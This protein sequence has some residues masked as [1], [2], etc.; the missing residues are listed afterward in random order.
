M[1][2]RDPNHEPN[3]H[4]YTSVEYSLPN[5][6]IEHWW[7]IYDESFTQINKN[8]P[9]RQ[10][11]YKDEFYI[12]MRSE[13]IHKV[14]SYERGEPSAMM[15]FGPL[16]KNADVFGWMSQDFYKKKYPRQSQSDSVLYFVG[17]FTDPNVRNQGNMS[18]LLTVGGQVV[19]EH[20]PDAVV[21]FDCCD[22][23]DK[24]LPQ[25]IHG[26]SKSLPGI[27][28]QPIEKA[29]TQRYYGFEVSY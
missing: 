17:I 4:I 15:I 25:T 20:H 26:L 28:V 14:V 19:K 29:G 27:T 13:N 16:S 21:I 22:E 12:A 7:G 3:L 18:G 1:H 5:D 6:I 11:M 24:W 9:C 2:E 23:N 8:S 10:S